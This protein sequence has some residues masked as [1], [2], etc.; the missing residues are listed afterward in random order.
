ML[1][2]GRLNVLALSLGVFA[3]LVSAGMYA[4]N[5]GVKMLDSKGFWKVMA[6]KQPSIIAFV[7]PWCGHCQQMI[8]EYSK[9]AQS[10]NPLI[11][12]YA[13]DCD[14]EANKFLC[15]GQRVQGFPTLKLYPRGDQLPA[16]DY[17]GGDRKANSIVKWAS[18]QLPN[19]THKLS[20]VDEIKSWA[21]KNVKSHRVLLLTKEKKVP[22]LWKVLGNKYKG[23]LHLGVL[24]NTDGDIPKKMGLKE[25]EVKVV[26]Y[27]AGTS[28]PLVYQGDT[29]LEPLTQ[30]FDS[31]LD[32]T[33]DIL[34]R[35]SKDEL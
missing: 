23:K 16:K 20:N 11:P 33:A 24:K 27:P 8:P 9:A 25:K 32:G 3:E 13:I 34:T 31:V 29:K 6:D 10:L 26:V 2:S 15:S 28:K 5:S 19:H 1:V 14:N 18:K 4:A 35:A 7:A 12:A 17:A 21:E 30:F 22:L